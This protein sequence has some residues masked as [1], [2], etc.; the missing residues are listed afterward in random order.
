MYSQRESA[1]ISPEQML[2]CTW[3][4]E[5]DSFRLTLERR[6]RKDG[7]RLVMVTSGNG[8]RRTSRFANL[9]ELIRFQSDMEAFLL[10]T[11]WSFLR[12]SP[13]R[14]RGR[15]RR[16]FP[17]INDRRRWWTDGTTPLHRVVWTGSPSRIRSASAENGEFRRLPG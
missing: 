17:R 10:K 2:T 4:F 11:G 9:S 13:E 14:R 7:P 12:Y 5:R 8:R 16:S 3:T 1:D 6:E 15:D